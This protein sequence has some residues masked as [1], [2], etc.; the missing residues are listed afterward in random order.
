MLYRENPKNG[1]K[2]SQLGFGCLR[3]P[4]K[5]Q[6]ID[7]VKTTELVHH[8]I[9]NGINYFDTA[10]IYPGSEAA[11]GKALAGGW[12]EKIKITTKMPLFFVRTASDFDKFFE[13]Q[14]E[15]LQTDYIDYYM[16][17]MLTSF[18]A[19][20]KFK[21]MGL[22][23]WAEKE[24][25]KGRIINLGFS[26]HGSYDAFTRIVDSYDWD[27]CMIQYNYIDENHQAGVKGL[28]YASDKG[29]PVMIMEPLRGGRL[30]DKLPEDAANAFKNVDTKR[31]FAD[32]GLR[33]V[34]NHPEVTLLLSGM[35]TMQQ[36]S[37]NLKIAS[38]VR[39]NSVTEH[40]KAAYAEALAAIR[41]TILVNCTGCGYCVPCPKNVNIPGT[42]SHFNDSVIVGKS[43]AKRKY[44]VSHGVL[45]KKSAFASQC[46][47]CGK[48]EAHCPQDI[49]II[50]ELEKAEAVLESF[51]MKPVSKIARLFTQ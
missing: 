40:E 36:L 47:K 38:E 10:Y 25:E 4:K 48:C 15:R 27:I 13:K 16:L 20:E 28:K 7:I 26:F 14:L 29:I 22:L 9:D 21:D 37:E 31:S 5:G 3:F 42:F 46:V 35:T 8:A 39:A 33:W 41:K 6:S 2:L 12:R 18:E 51:W 45:A 43:R 24:R 44:L 23:E 19:F 49:Q 50:E 17:H 34:W 1:D 30:T 32:W 11:L